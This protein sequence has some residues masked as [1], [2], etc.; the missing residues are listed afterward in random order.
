MRKLTKKGFTLVELLVVVVILAIVAAIA[1]RSITGIIK[2]NR[3]DSFASSVN[4][5]IEAAELTCIQE[6]GA[7]TDENIDKYLKENDVSV[8]VSGSNLIV[9]A[10][11]NGEFAGL[12]FK[13]VNAR[14]SKFKAGIT[15]ATS[16]D[17]NNT[18]TT[19]KVSVPY[20]C[21]E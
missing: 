14:S 11:E 16:N 6:S 15:N 13:D 4:A 10:N 9:S 7:L 20:V 3:I 8:T 12:S 21:S 1:M 19:V 17:T 5:A 18:A 2:N